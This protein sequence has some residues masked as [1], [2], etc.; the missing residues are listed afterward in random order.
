MAALSAMSAGCA[1]EDTGIACPLLAPGALV[2][3]ADGKT[4]AVGATETGNAAR[5][6]LVAH[7]L[8]VT[9]GQTLEVKAS[10]EGTLALA[11]YGPRDAFGGYPHCLDIE[12]GRSLTAKLGPVAGEYLVLVGAA[13]GG[14]PV[15]YTLEVTCTEGCESDA[16]R[17]PTL[18]DQ[19]C[20]DMRCD[21]ELSRD[22]A[23]CL[24]CECRRD[25]LCGPDRQAG[26]SGSCVLPACTGCTGS[27]VCGADGRTWP[28]ACSAGCAGV[29]VVRDEACEIACPAL[30]ACETACHGLRTLDTTGCPTCECRSRFAVDA[31]NCAAC[32]LTDAPVCGT[33]GLTYT[34]A[35]RAR[36]HGARVLYAG[37]CV[38]G[39]TSAPEGCQLDCA[40]GLTPV[41]GGA[42]CLACACAN[43]PSTCNVEAGAPVCVELPG[44]GETTVG[45]ACL[46]LALGVSGDAR[47]GPCGTR[48]DTE[49]PCDEGT[50]VGGGFLEGRCLLDDVAC[51]CPALR[52]PV[53][54]IDT[55][56]ALETFDNACILRCAGSLLV[57]TGACCEGGTTCDDGEVALLDASGCVSG[58]RPAE[59]ADCAEG[60]ATGAACTDDGALLDGSAC[61][62]HFRGEAAFLELCR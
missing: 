25:G 18:A 36:C 55:E 14:D 49:N 11:S 13:V 44:V 28:S 37:A 56:G 35:C 57:H 40:H 38:D 26:P 46:A 1:G 3:H 2:L 16:P 30:G 19:G 47:W 62:A 6:A 50:C 23:G 15:A 10:S 34:N 52:A 58:C 61:E 17:C 60:A 7:P 53:C 42:H 29:P 39:C 4:L 22:A 45:S 31:V 9:E 33:D 27:P 59:A 54:G 20:G 48:C 21:G 8:T 51:G 24:T 41:A 43:V 5:G 12:Q 32:P